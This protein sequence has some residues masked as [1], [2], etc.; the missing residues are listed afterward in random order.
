MSDTQSQEST[1]PDSLAGVIVTVPN[2]VVFRAFAS[3]TVVL[4]I[5]T[6]QYHGLNQVAGRM[7]E[8]LQRAPDLQ[9]AAQALAGEFEQS[10]ERIEQDLRAFCD[11][12]ASR[13]LLEIDAAGTR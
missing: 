10:L 3:E 5:D 8:T 9:T 7:L 13:G 4:N 6:G 2:H 12:L 11:D 1:I